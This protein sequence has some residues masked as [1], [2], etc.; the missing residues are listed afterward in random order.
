MTRSIPTSLLG[1]FTH[2]TARKHARSTSNSPRTL[3]GAGLAFRTQLFPVRLAL[4]AT[5]CTSVHHCVLMVTNSM[6]D[7]QAA[8]EAIVAASNDTEALAVA[9]R[10]AAFLDA[11]P[12]EARQKL[13]GA[14]PAPQQAPGA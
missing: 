8:L 6:G 11:T 14:A 7:A 4:P 3:E 1:S 13:R 5:V 9:I 10:E 2:F 12:G